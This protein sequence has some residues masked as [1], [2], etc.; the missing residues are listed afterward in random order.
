M[1]SA[2]GLFALVTGANKG[3]GL[4][5]ARQLGQAGLRVII[6]ARDAE[7]GKKA[8]QTLGNEG[9]GARY[10]H[11][12]LTDP[13]SVEQAAEDIRGREGAL[14]IL[15]NNAG[16]S[17]PRDGSPAHA[18][19]DAV[20][21][22]F[23]TNFLGTLSVTQAM[24]PLLRKASPARIINLSSGLGSLTLNGDP[25]WEY[26]AYKLIGYN[27]SKAAVNMLTVQLA[28]E[29]RESGIRV[30]AADPGFTATDLNGHQ[31]R[32][33]IPQ[34]AA[35]AVRLALSDEDGETGGYFATDGRVPW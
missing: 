13:A 17:D 22:V 11:L 25:S 34:G 29:L 1:P 20:R 24:L 31:G 28:A 27:A 19:L 7:R 3:I 4:E 14:N 9:I 8:A 6:G 10:L 15:V 30:N 16:I 32:Q 12:D 21:R 33:T 18:E 2:A 35:E 23:E 26:S 5:I